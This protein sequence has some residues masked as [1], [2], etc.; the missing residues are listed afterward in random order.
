[1]L[2]MELLAVSVDD[3]ARGILKGY[4]RGYPLRLQSTGE[5]DYLE[6]EQKCAAFEALQFLKSQAAAKMY[7]HMS[8]ITGKWID[9]DCL[10]AEARKRAKNGKWNVTCEGDFSKVGLARRDAYV[11]QV[12]KAARIPKTIRDLVKELGADMASIRQTLN[13]LK[14]KGR[15]AYDKTTKEWSQTTQH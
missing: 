14:N 15:V 11:E 3:V 4:L 6:M 5:L 7:D 2:V 10:L 1:M 12:Y 8:G 9:S 13:S